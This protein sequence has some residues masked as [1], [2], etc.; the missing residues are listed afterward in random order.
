MPEGDTIFRAARTL[1]RALRGE[2]VTKFESAFP[3]L[4]RVDTDR[5]IAGRTI[6]AVGSRGKHLLMTFT[7]DLTLHTHMRMNG[8]W[9][10]YRPGERWQRS[11]DDMR[12]LIA[13][14]TGVAVGFTIPVAEWL[15]GA[16]LARHRDLASLGPDPLA[17]SFDAAAAAAGIRAQTDQPIG[18]VLLNQRI[19]AGIGNV[20]KSETLF[21]AGINPFASVGSL[22]D[23]VIVRIVSIARK[24]LMASVAVPAH[25]AAAA[26]GR[27]PTRSMDPDAR[28][29]VY[30]RAGKP[31]RKCGAL[32]EA[33]KTGNDARI[34]YWCPR[35]QH[36]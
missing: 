34:S 14:P 27:R 26:S 33:K 29:W 2:V 32:I 30:G 16:E 13:T 36:L 5:R 25:P 31:C 7:G 9:H 23:A 28:L 22:D 24:L 15:S 12:I 10:L 19:I 11:S 18:E 1:E 8:S 21:V 35:C 17:A 20:L 4:T 3:A 6:E